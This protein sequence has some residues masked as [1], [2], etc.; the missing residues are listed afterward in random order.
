M[1]NS[2]RESWVSY[3][4]YARL[5]VTDLN[6]RRGTDALALVAQWRAQSGHLTWFASAAGVVV[7][8][9]VVVQADRVV[10]Q[11]VQ[12]LIELGV[13]DPAEI[14]HEVTVADYLIWLGEDLL[15]R[16]FPPDPR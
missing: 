15:P 9:G 4:A 3:H 14:V 8:D 16:F 5:L 2:A 13:V 7:A 1:G 10:V 6:R 11:A 12:M